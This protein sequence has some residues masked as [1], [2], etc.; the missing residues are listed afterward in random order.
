M[1]EHVF[2]SDTN[3]NMYRQPINVI[4]SIFGVLFEFNTRCLA[5][6][7]SAHFLHGP[8]RVSERAGWFRVMSI[9]L[10][11]ILKN[12]ETEMVPG[13]GLGVGCGSEMNMRWFNHI[14][15]VFELNGSGTFCNSPKGDE[16]SAE[17][18]K[19]PAKY[20]IWNRSCF[21]R[22]LQHRRMV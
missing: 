4:G 3:H 8:R 10:V 18:A 1:S 17:Q 20:L 7:T 19:A 11:W 12:S 9:N 14:R 5:C 21:E 15:N 22:M 13:I 6:A 16:D 2:E